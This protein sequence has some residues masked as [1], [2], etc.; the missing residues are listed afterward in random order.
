MPDE[1]SNDLL[2]LAEAVSDGEQVDWDAEISKRPDLQVALERLKE[3]QSL[4]SVFDAF[5]KEA[6]ANPKILLSLGEVAD[7]EE[8]TGD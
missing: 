4:T 1:Q 2:R 8:S 5:C 6:Q 7:D 3:M